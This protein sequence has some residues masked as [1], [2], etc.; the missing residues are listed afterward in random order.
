MKEYSEGSRCLAS[1]AVFRELYNSEMDIYAI[2]GEF[3]KEVIAANGKHQFT[4]TEITQLLNDFYEFKIPE[5]VVSTSLGRFK[6]SLNRSYGT[7]SITDHTTFSTIG[8]ISGKHSSIQIDH[9]IIIQQLYK[10]IEEEKRNTL[11]KE[12]KE[13]IVQSLCS[14]IIDESSS[15]EYS[16]YV[17]AFIVKL[18][19]DST[20]TSKLNTIKE[21]V[22]LYTGLKY[23]SSLGNL[24]NW[25]TELTI[26]IDTEILFHFAGYNGNLFET[27]FM[28]FYSLVNEVNTN[29]IKRTGKSLIH[30]KYF[31][32][33]KEEVNRFFKKA[34][35]F[36]SGKEKAN[37]S[38][39]AM[40]SI[41][42]GCKSR[43]DVIEKKTLFDQLLI[44][45]GIEEDNYKEF[46]YR[47]NHKYNIEDKELLREISCK[48][49]EEEAINC[50][51]YLNYINIHR[52]GISN[53]GFEH[54]GFVLLSGT[55]NILQLANNESIKDNGDVPLAINL[56]FVTN[57]LW[58]RLNK[59]FGKGVYPKTFN[60]VTKAQIVLSTQ[61]NNS[62]A[63]K[64][65][66]LQIKFKSGD[67]TEE[68][69][70]AIIAELRRQA[71]KPEDI[72]E[73]DVEDVLK[74]IEESTIEKHLQEQ[75]WLKNEYTMQKNENTKLKEELKKKEIDHQMKEQKLKESLRLK[76]KESQ[77]KDSE[78]QIFRDE[79]SKR[80][81]RIRKIKVFL[82]ASIISV[83]I[84]G[85]IWLYLQNN[86]II[87]AIGFII[88]IIGGILGIMLF[89]GVDYKAARKYYK[90]ML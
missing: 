28:D 73:H 66:E 39:T 67:L 63:D 24:G 83:L 68:Q 71:K 38:K 70:T 52:K 11:T 56:T 77:E 79:Q 26:Y 80:I 64:F 18:K 44:R 33:V 21:G 72:N 89:L 82:L 34:E 75:A 31:S 10:Y 25:N 29:S 58:F 27:L 60:I 30:L 45:N 35:D 57:K 43:A 4:L 1:L 12:E 16:D 49:D 61:L 14:F 55:S 90:I 23:D 59:G 85:S 17:S 86:K 42:N 36:V 47:E 5:A 40:S 88:S 84:V 46:Y 15:H 7:Y 51:K 76:E 8:K 3:L 74:S 13:K 6:K 48:M 54:V 19:N 50:L 32:G 81:K 62:V 78:I 65:E 37:P 69:A 20:L 2:I 22:V 87:A 9:E 53:K 41:I